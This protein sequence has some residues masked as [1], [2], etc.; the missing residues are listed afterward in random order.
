[1]AFRQSISPRARFLLVLLG[2]YAL[3]LPVISGVTY[4]I[5]KGEAVRHANRLG[6]LYLGALSHVKDY[7]GDELRPALYHALPGTFL[8]EGMSRNYVAASLA[9]RL[10]NEGLGIIYKDAALG[11][12]RRPTNRADVFEARIV[13][14]FRQSPA[15]KEWRGFREM[16]APARGGEAAEYYVIARPGEPYKK[17]C[18]MCHGVPADAPAEIVAVYGDEAGFGYAEGSLADAQ[19]VY[20]PIT[21]PLAEA[22]RMVA[23]F[24]G[25][26]TVAFGL[27]FVFISVRFNRLY[28]R[29]QTYQ[30]R[31]NQVNV[32]LTELVQEMDTLVA[33]RTVSLMGLTVADR[34]RNPASVIGA[35]CRRLLASA[36]LDPEVREGIAEISAEA[37]RL[38]TIVKEFESFHQGRKSVFKYIALADVIADARLLLE[39]EAEDS[40]VKLVIESAPEPL[41]VNAQRRLLAA[42]LLFAVRNA[43]EATPVGGA[44]TLAVSAADGEACVTVADTGSGIPEE[45]MRRLF[46]PFFSTKLLR[47]GVGLPLVK[48]I[49]EEH[50]GHVVVENAAGG[51]TVIRLCFPLH[52]VDGSTALSHGQPRDRAE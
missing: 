22:R 10:E 38:E 24:I 25:F 32:Q 31:T 30:E 6:A 47:Y 43:I 21:L 3:S 48:Q 41:R 46:D 33:E 23:I 9:S 18:L 51:G 11:N 17:D 35:N 13:E 49:V 20:I 15:P 39:K 1:M 40:G 14:E 50:L 27:A 5:L 4:V 26:Y 52:W 2:L 29:I 8:L 44:V 28:G 16:P 19:F 37:D 7:V 42:A 12:P 36:A 34:I 45:D